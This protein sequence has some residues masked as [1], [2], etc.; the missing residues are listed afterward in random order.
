MWCHRYYLR[1]MCDDVKF[2]DWEVRVEQH[3]AAAA[4]TTAAA[5]VVTDIQAVR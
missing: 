2:G 3:H 4:A 1:N 5:V